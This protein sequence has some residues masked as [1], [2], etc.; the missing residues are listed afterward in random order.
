M[1][2]PSNKKAPTNPQAEQQKQAKIKELEK[3]I[4]VLQDELDNNMGL[5]NMAKTQKKKLMQ[6]LMIERNKLLKGEWSDPWS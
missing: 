5:N 2:P 3:Q 1:E 6:S 4:K